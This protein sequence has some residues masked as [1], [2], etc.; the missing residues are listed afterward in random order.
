MTPKL[1]SNN[2][3]NFVQALTEALERAKRGEIRGMAL[4]TL[5]G[6]LV[7]SDI[8][9]ADKTTLTEI[10]GSLPCAQEKILELMNGR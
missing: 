9:K 6:D 1:V 7:I 4:I 8:V 5:E 10:M 2:P 3:P